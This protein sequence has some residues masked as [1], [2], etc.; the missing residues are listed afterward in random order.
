MLTT[1]SRKERNTL[2]H[3]VTILFSCG[4]FISLEISF[5]LLVYVVHIANGKTRKRLSSNEPLIR[6][7][8]M[9]VP[10]TATGNV[11]MTSARVISHGRRM[12]IRDVLLEKRCATDRNFTVFSRSVTTRTG[13][14]DAT[15]VYNEK[16]I[17]PYRA[18][19][20]YRRR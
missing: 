16:S 14:C 18:S 9:K 3:T 8:L 7:T 15:H 13:T 5:T 6:K 10:A 2:Q 20:Q 1:L 17:L 19:A 12:S 11:T 4:V